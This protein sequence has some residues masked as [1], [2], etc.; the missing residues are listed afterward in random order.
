LKK[1][2]EIY[3][4]AELFIRIGV[5]DSAALCQ[6]SSKFGAKISDCAK[7]LK[8]A[9]EMG[10]NVVGLSFHV[11]SGQ[12]T[13][14]AYVDALDRARGIFDLAESLGTPFSVLDIGGGFPGEDD[15]EAYFGFEQIA[16]IINKKNR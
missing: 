5:D 16:Q 12:Q 7:L 8:S 15:E 13:C 1:I 3:P 4:E 10:L 14:D 2:R 9:N 6:L 11:G